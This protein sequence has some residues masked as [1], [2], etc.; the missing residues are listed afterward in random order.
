MIDDLLR[1]AKMVLF[2]TVLFIA[3]VIKW[4]T[5]TLEGKEWN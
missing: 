3:S 5:Q 4:L 2:M 1:F